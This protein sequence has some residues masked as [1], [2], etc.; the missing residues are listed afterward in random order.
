MYRAILPVFQ[1]VPCFVA[2]SYQ[3]SKKP[4]G[5]NFELAGVR[6]HKQIFGDVKDLEEDP[7]Q[8][9]EADFSRLHLLH[10]EHEQEMKLKREQKK[11]YVIRHKYFRTEKLPNFLTWAEKEQI[12]HLYKTQP[13]E[14]PSERLAQSFPAVEEIIIKIINAKWTP[15]NMKRIQKHDES[16]KRNWELFKSKQMPNLDPQI[17]D[18][19]Q[20]F[21]NRNFDNI[22]NAYVQTNNEQTEFQ[23][24]KPKSQEFLHMVASCNRKNAKIETKDNSRE[25]TIEADRKQDQLSLPSAENKLKV[26]RKKRYEYM[27]YD[28]LMEINTDRMSSTND[29]EAHL[30]VSLLEDPIVNEPDVTTQTEQ[31]QNPSDEPD[32]NTYSDQSEDDKVIDLTVPDARSLKNVQQ[33]SIIKKYATKTVSLEQMIDNKPIPF[34]HKVFIPKKLHKPGCV[35]KFDDCFYDDK[36]EFLY[37]VPGLMD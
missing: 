25:N 9:V 23:F 35:Y 24:P 8:G 34:K 32:E 37:R 3:R 29:E 19:L 30:S 18:H 4:N 36:G 26:P 14:W 20:K 16:V 7:D 13:D 31:M 33:S 11:Y 22:Q 5:K 27:T 1:R 6:S 17:R 10:R 21:S 2:R 15:A 28:G 12:R